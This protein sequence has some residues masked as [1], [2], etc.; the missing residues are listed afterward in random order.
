VLSTLK[1]Y[2]H[3]FVNLFRL[4]Y[5]DIILNRKKFKKFSVAVNDFSINYELSEKSGI[6]KTVEL[7]DLM[8]KNDTTDK[9]LIEN[10]DYKQ[11]NVTLYELYTLCSVAN[12]L[13]PSTVFE[14]GTFDGNTALHLALNTPDYTIIHTLDIPPEELEKTTLKLDSGDAQLIEKK[15]FKTGQCF[16][17]KEASKKIIQHLSDSAKFNYS[18]FVNKI[19]MFFVDG[20]HSYEYIEADTNIAFET[21][22]ENGIILWHD[23]GNVSDVADYLNELSKSKTIYRIN[24]TSLAIYA[25]KLLPG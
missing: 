6:L 16:L 24:N 22:R 17:N 1:Y 13:K 2:F 10:W 7:Y 23:Y 12:F 25:P 5:I 18:E 20:A 11:G 19:D 14:I 8:N 21:I 9:V 15:G 3:F 4:G